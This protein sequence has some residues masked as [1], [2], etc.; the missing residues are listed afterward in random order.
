M[1]I[2]LQGVIP[3]LQVFDMPASVH[4]YR[5]LLEFEVVNAS[6]PLS[7]QPDDCN[8]VLL[9]RQGISLM[10]NTAYD[11]GERPALPDAKRIAAHDDI[12]L[13]FA[14]PDVDGA[15][16]HLQSI[17]L[18]IAKPSMAGYGMNQLYLKDP[19]GYGLCFQW[20]A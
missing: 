4:F 9:Q 1:S 17:G 8:W 11:E 12:T 6:Q 7:T 18:Q 19:D 14:C 13:Y 16:A 15:Y 10:L 3:L 20:P 2:E 5:D